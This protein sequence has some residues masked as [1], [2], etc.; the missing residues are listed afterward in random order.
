MENLKDILFLVW[1]L[2]D[3]LIQF[4]IMVALI[5][6]LDRIGRMAWSIDKR[7]GKVNEMLQKEVDKNN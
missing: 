3:T 4:G 5:G 6:G 1:D 7:L 2:F